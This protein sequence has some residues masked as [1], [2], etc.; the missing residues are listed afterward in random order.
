[1]EVMYVL[2]K[3]DKPLIASDITQINKGLNINTVQAA[4]RKLLKQK[5]ICISDIVYSR[6]VLTR[7]YEP[8]ISQ[9]ELLAKQFVHQYKI[10]NEDV[11][12]PSLVANLLEN[13]KNENKVI[14]EL[15][16]ILE[17]RRK[18]LGKEV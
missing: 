17:E 10:K 7:S 16:K 6:T 5:Y 14:D 11:S 12:I 8:V 13:E 3:S 9:E 18:E 2:W 1:M 4:L 15:E